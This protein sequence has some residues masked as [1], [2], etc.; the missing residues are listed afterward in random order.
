MIY[1]NIVRSLCI[2]GGGKLLEEGCLGH[3]ASDAGGCYGADESCR[4]GE[5]GTEGIETV[6]MVQIMNSLR[7]GDKEIVGVGVID[8]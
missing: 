3:V 6:G 4:R 1:Y 8:I 2:A 5:Q 7:D